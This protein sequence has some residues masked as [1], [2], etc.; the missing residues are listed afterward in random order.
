MCR[1]LSIISRLD[2]AG[3][4]ILIIGSKFAPYSSMYCNFLLAIF[5]ERHHV[6]R[7]NIW[8]NEAQNMVWICCSRS[9]YYLFRCTLSF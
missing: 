8:E 6:G 9:Y 7:L 1:S 2:Y 5:S 4:N 3:V